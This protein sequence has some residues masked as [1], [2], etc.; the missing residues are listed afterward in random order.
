V[1]PERW[2][3]VK[4]L[5][6]RALERAPGE[7][8]AFLKEACG[9]DAALRHEVESLL[10]AAEDTA[11]FL[12]PPPAAVAPAEGDGSELAA[13]LAAAL[14]DRYALERELGRG[15][16]ATVY[17]A[18]DLKHG[19]PVALKV[20]HPEIAAGLGTERFLREIRLTARL[21]HPHILPVFDSGAAA[22][23]PWYTMPYVRGESL[24]D[25]LRREVQL[26]VETALEITRQV[27]LALEYAHR[28][29]VVHRDIKP[30]NV[31]LS[32]GQALVADFGV[33]RAVGVASEE[34]LTGTGMALG[35]PAYMAPEQASAGQ[36]DRRTDVYA[37]GCVLYE[38]L[39]GEAPFTGPTPQAIMA[40]RFAQPAPSVLIVRPNVPR[41]AD[42]AIRKAMAPVPADRF[43][44]AAEFAE[45]LDRSSLP[46]M[47][48]TEASASSDASLHRWKRLTR[49]KATAVGALAVIGLGAAV[50]HYL[51][52]RSRQL[53]SRDTLLGAGIL[54]QRERLLLADF[55]T[56]QVDSGLG[57][58][59]T[60][61]FRIDLAQSPAVTLVPSGQVAEVL[62]RME[63]PA[64][65]RL[66]PALA[67]EIAVREGIKAVVTG[68]I[69]RAG[70][71]YLLSAQ[72]IA[73]KDGEM[74]T[75]HRV[76]AADSTRLIA[77]VDQL[78]GELRASV[79]ESLKR[80]DRE[81]P[82]DRVTT[83]SLPAL[84]LYS[85]AVRAADHEGDFGKAFTYLEE[86]VA[87]DTGFAMAYRTLGMHAANL[88]KLDQ[89]FEGYGAA[90][91]RLDR[92]TDRERQF[93]LG[94]YYLVVKPDL[95]RAAAAY[96][97]ILEDHPNDREALMGL[98]NVDFALRRWG[99]AGSLYQRA[100]AADSFYVQGY[101]NLM[102]FQIT[103]KQWDQA[104]TTYEQAIRHLP[105]VP[106]FRELGVRLAE[107]RGDYATARARAQELLKHFGADPGLGADAHRHLA[108]VAAARGQLTEAERHLREA[109]AARLKAGRTDLY[110][111]EVILLTSLTVAVAGEP[112]TGVSELERALAQHPLRSLQPMDRP[113]AQL[114]AAFAMAGRVDRARALLAEYEQVRDPRWR[115]GGIIGTDHRKAALELSWGYVGLA[116]QHWP[117]AIARFQA[118][119]AEGAT[120]A[121]GLADLGHAYDLRGQ[122]DSAI[123]VYERYLDAPDPLDELSGM[124]RGT[125]A[126]ELPAIYR[127]L[128]ELYRW[129]GDSGKARAYS[130]RFVELWKDCDPRLRPQVIQA[131]QLAQGRD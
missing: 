117:A 126:I 65:A 64:T 38:L 71:Q 46:I 79:G 121:F 81:P 72:V 63:R 119:V 56:R 68:D 21:Q 120:P 31:L 42:E 44:D 8:P 62:A 51:T 106:Y 40:K 69:A 60:E 74:L 91:Q 100:V 83:A 111:A 27:A 86:A 70:P 123:A 33:A 19:R 55:G 32:E 99:Q 54:A 107:R 96:E 109:M 15:G 4:E 2:Q 125:L 10:A 129:R 53:T 50:T 14:A 101:N 57:G 90:M 93:T 37:L 102:L 18:Q 115:S 5:L 110:L 25:R 1:T 76:T 34:A 92:L 104:Q 66:D 3:A 128:G 130:T 6:A 127:R 131:R 108:I 118:A 45:A 88:G 95:P 58:V 17:L 16:M 94:D 97:A 85:A 113:Y 49:Q 48:G 82:L 89:V 20:L 98:G 24:R 122:V 77:A 23:Q 59:L 75:A 52:V 28:E 7:R 67:R 61:A 26:S 105:N 35:T 47:A 114:A 13:R 84:R 22:G 36:I 112:S 39:A 73:A 87:L 9:A 29:G 43:R 103:L 116:E 30:E 80:I 124:D 41:A 12:E 78:S 11:G